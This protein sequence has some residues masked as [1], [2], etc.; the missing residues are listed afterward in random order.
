MEN[1]IGFLILIFTLIISVVASVKK[2]SGQNKTGEQP[3]DITSADSSGDE[4]LMEDVGYQSDNKKTG[5][6]D[7]VTDFEEDTKKG[8]EEAKE[9]SGKEDASSELKKEER[10]KSTVKTDHAKTSSPLKETRKTKKRKTQKKSKIQ[11]IKEKFD[12]EEGIIYSEII[13]RKYF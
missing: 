4:L 1:I 10:Q 3:L 6:W 7:E 5:S 13:N 2:Q 11:S 8:E 9:I 12:I